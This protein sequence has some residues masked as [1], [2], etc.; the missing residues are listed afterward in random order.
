MKIFN[1]LA[2]PAV[3]YGCETWAI[4]EQDKFTKTSAEIKFMRRRAK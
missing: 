1:T 3:L 2:L 4:R